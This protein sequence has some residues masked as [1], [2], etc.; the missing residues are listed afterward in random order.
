MARGR[1]IGRGRGRKIPLMTIGS[2]VGTRVEGDELQMQDQSKTLPLNEEGAI[3]KETLSSAEV[4]RRLSLNTPPT[5]ADIRELSDLDYDEEKEAESNGTVKVDAENFVD[6]ARTTGGK[7]KGKEKSKD[8]LWTNMFKN[9]RAANNDEVQVEEDKWKCARITYVIGECPG[10]NTM[11]RY[12]TMNWTAVTKPDVYL[13][14]ERILIEVNVTKAIPQQI[15]V[16]DP[17]G[18]IFMQEVVLEWRPQFCDK[19]QKIGHQ[20][21]SGITTKEGPPK[22]RRPVKKVTQVW[23]YKWPIQIKE[24]VCAQNR[25]HEAREI[26]HNITTE[27]GNHE[28]EKEHGKQNPGEITQLNLRPNTG[29]IPTRNGFESL[30]DIK[31]ASLP[32]DRGATPTLADEVAGLIETRVNEHNMTATLRGIAPGW[33]IMYNYN[34]AVYGRIWVIWDEN[35]YENNIIR[36]TAQIVH[37]M[38][39]DRTKGHQIVLTVIYGY[40]TIEQRKE[41]WL[42]LNTLAQ[43][44]A[45]PWLIAGIFNALLTPQDRLA[46]AKVSL[47]EMKDFAE[48]VKDIDVTELQW[49]EHYYSWTNKQNGND[50][51]STRID[52]FFGNYEWM[53]K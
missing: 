30:M 38:I 42:E 1:G 31:L 45:Q 47:N 46:G 8:E 16:M 18:G 21:Q 33:G 4:V 15:T 5:K 12:I 43:G 53:E 41:L 40:N 14:D 51:I 2:S 37:C 6:T 35:W 36:C 44:I 49:M 20:C 13:H 17:N 34:A 11:N 24:Q 10:Y 27:K 39:K 22:K 52:K 9:N 7:S 32:I 48:C 19:C 29:A 23:Q 26:S 50:R 3:E 25:G 28:I